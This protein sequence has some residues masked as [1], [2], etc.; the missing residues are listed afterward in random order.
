MS[1]AIA[2]DILFWCTLINFGLLV[3][4]GLLMV[5]PHEW[6]HRLCG[7]WLRLSA[8]QIDAINFAGIL[9]YEILIILFNLVPYIALLIVGRG[10]SA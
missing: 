1:I 4:W 7:R 6:V 2:R 9:L 5:A 3:A 10:S 8:E